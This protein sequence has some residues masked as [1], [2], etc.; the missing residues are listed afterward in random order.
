MWSY[1]KRSDLSDAVRELLSNVKYRSIQK[2]CK[3]EIRRAEWRH[4]NSTTQEGLD[5]N[6]T[7]PFWNFVK[8]RRRDNV[9]VS[10]LK[11][12]GRLFSNPENKVEILLKQF[13]SAFSSDND[14]PPPN[15]KAT[16]APPI[17]PIKI[18]SQGIAKLLSDLQPHKAPGPDCIPNTVLKPCANNIAPALS[19]IYQRSLDTGT[20]PSDWFTA[21]ISAAFKKGDRHLAENYRPISLT[22]MPCKIL[23]HVICRHLLNHLENNKILF[24]TTLNHGFHSGYSCETQLLTTVHDFVTSFENNKQ[25][26]V[27][28]LDFSKAFDT[29]P[30]KKLLH[31][32]HQYGITGPIHSWLQNFLTRRTM[33]VVVDGCC[34]DSTS[35]DSGVPQGTVLGPLLFLCYINNLPDSAVS[36]VRL[37]ADDCLLYREINTFQDHITLQQDLK[38]L[39]SWA[40]TWG[41]RL[42]A[43]KCYILSI[44]NKS[45]FRY[46]LNNTILK[47]VPNNPYLGIL[48][49]QDLKW[50]DHIA[51]ITKNA[52]STLGF[53]RRN[54][55]HCPTSC[56][57]NSYLSLVRSVLEYGSVVWDP[58]LKKDIDALERVQRRAARFIAGDYCSRSTGT[59]Q[60]L[61]NKLKLTEL[62]DRRKQ[63]RLILFF[64]V[65]E[66]LVPAIPAD[67]LTKQQKPGRL[68]RSSTDK[69]FIS[70]N[71]INSYI[72]NNDRCFVV[73]TCRTDQ[74]RNSFFCRT[75]VEWNHLD[76]NIVY[77]A[78]VNSFRTAISQ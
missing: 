7:K 10:P 60:R 16:N 39:E 76:N 20:L 70:S 58:Y 25:V 11:V 47:E 12:N 74:L 75:V 56:R 49:S 66:G 71:T 3:R 4:I 65:V 22:S 43:T 14:N 73:H 54:L 48:L 31:K 46:S 52:N 26:D 34:S 6:N 50:S 1:N 9:G 57:R 15:T 27:A 32:L 18:S 29:V 23:E 77:S 67:K 63:L 69:N 13:K 40:D 28:I 68:I 59:V 72:R 62:Q 61:L 41:M 21:N 37:F 38:N 51:S 5:N 33:R 45:N 64:K 2:R 8:A 78:S 55:R 17:Q 30:H 24:L 19:L 42:N 36:Q 53:L 44:N 35:V